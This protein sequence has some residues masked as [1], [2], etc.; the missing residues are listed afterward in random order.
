MPP[1]NVLSLFTGAG[2]LDLGLEA[3]G[4]EISGCVERD[5]DCRRTLEANTQWRLTENGDIEQ[6]R[7]ES[8][9][10][11]LELE[12]GEITLLAGGPPCQPFSKS[13]Q[14]VSGTTTKM[15]DPRAKTLHAYFEILEAALPRVMLL[16]N[17]KGLV[18]KPRMGGTEEQALQVLSTAL[19]SINERHGTEYRPSI[20]QMDAA[21][22]G[23]AQKRERVFVI[24]ERDGGA[25]EEP[26]PTHGKKAPVGGPRF[27]TAWDALWDL[28]VE[29]WDR[30]LAPRGYWGELLPSIPEGRNYL[31]HTRKGDGEPLFGWRRKYWSFLLKLAKDRPSWTLQA[32]PGPATGPFHWRSRSLSIREMAR[33]QTFPD[34]HDFKG[35]YFSARRQVG[36]AVPVAL[37]QAIGYEIRRQLL[38]DQHS[39]PMTTLPAQRDDCPPA[40]EPQAVAAKYLGLRGEHED[41]PGAGEGPRA[42]TLKSATAVRGT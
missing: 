22:V 29:D 19:H 10:E 13:G 40:E 11:E 20:V 42:T 6:L 36:N 15:S 34:R 24:A 17:V 41:H 38:G 30:E 8:V 7:P 27:S 1:M 33:L 26:R 18:A 28:D 4:F 31:H 32:Q 23:V 35:S 3:A 9:L 39:D 5:P 14:W 25:I 16:E 37:G 12:P 2:G 21:N